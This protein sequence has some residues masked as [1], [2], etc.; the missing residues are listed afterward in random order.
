MPGHPD[1]RSRAGFS[2]CGVY[3]YS[4]TRLWD[5]SRQRVCFCML[6]PSTADAGANDP[7]VRRCVGFALG[8]GFGSLDVVNIFAL[9][10]T[11]PAALSRH[12]DP[13]GP[14][15]DRA[16]RRAAGRAHLVVAA[17]GNHGDLLRRGR[18]VETMLLDAARSGTPVC[19]FGRTG[20]GHPRHPLY[21]PASAELVRITQ[22][23]SARRTGPGGA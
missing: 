23:T 9:R 15:N 21:L 16:I 10:S 8:H 7:T 17:W 6:N 3:R 5:T 13:I 14:G 4:L 22:A 11:D 12:P 1:A 2:R 20:A 19:H 18:V